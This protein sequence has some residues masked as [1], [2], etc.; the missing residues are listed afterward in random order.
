ME[1]R[2]LTSENPSGEEIDA[3][4]GFLASRRAADRDDIRRW[5][6][7]IS[8]LMSFTDQASR[9]LVASLRE[10]I[11]AAQRDLDVIEKSMRRLDVKESARNGMAEFDSKADRLAELSTRI[12][13]LAAEMANLLQESVTVSEELNKITFQL[14][15]AGAPL[16]REYAGGA[17]RIAQLLPA[18]TGNELEGLLQIERLRETALLGE[19]VSTRLAALRA[20]LEESLKKS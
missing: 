15:P 17:P 3:A 11:V 4:R 1:L 8:A 6:E 10:K 12:G 13:V 7:Q 20:V 19:F 14:L 2:A 16:R 18:S 5:E 9:N